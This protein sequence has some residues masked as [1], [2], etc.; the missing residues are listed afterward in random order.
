MAASGQ[1]QKPHL[2][3]HVL[4][5]DLDLLL[6]PLLLLQLLLTAL[7]LHDNCAKGQHPDDNEQMHITGTRASSPGT[8]HRLLEPGTQNSESLFYAVASSAEWPGSFKVGQ[9]MHKS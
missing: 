3:C 2:E 7:S 5:Q 9:W 8:S 6:L 1:N 4:P